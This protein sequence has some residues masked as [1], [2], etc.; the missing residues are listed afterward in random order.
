M[1]KAS[2]ILQVKCKKKIVE[3][4]VRNVGWMPTGRHSEKKKKSFRTIDLDSVMFI[5][6]N[7]AKQIEQ[8][9]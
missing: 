7:G 4:G 8:H 3:S 1:S 5:V 6:N 2:V 9:K